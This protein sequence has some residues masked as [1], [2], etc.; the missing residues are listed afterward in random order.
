VPRVSPEQVRDALAQRNAGLAIAI[1]GSFA[2]WLGSAGLGIAESLAEAYRPLD[3][4]G[5]AQVDQGLEA[6][7]GVL[8][9]GLVVAAAGTVLMTMGTRRLHKAT[10]A[11]PQGAGFSWR[12]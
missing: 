3:A 2:A 9:V 6:A 11:S 5:R 8:A 1:L 7:G 12:F 4:S 10:H